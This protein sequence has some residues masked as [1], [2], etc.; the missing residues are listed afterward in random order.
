MLVVLRKRNVAVTK[1][2][3]ILCV[4][5]ALIGC[6]SPP[7]APV[8]A[9]KLLAPATPPGIVETSASGDHGAARV[10]VWAN[11]PRWGDWDAPVT[12][13]EFGDLEC[14]L[15]KSATTI[16]DALKLQ[17]GPRKLRVIWKH[18]P[19]PSHASA[20][21]SAD[22]AAIVMGL[23]GSEAFWKFQALAL[24]HQD[25]LHEETYADWAEASGVRREVYREAREAE[26]FSSKVEDDV[27][28]AKKLDAS[29]TPSFR[30]NGVTLTGAATVEQFKTLI[31][32]E[33]EKAS[34][35]V[36]AGTRPADVYVTL[37][38]QTTATTAVPV[39]TKAEG[40]PD[41]TVW[42][43]P[44]F[45]D[46]P[47]LGPADALVTV[48]EFSDF[49]CSFC[50]RVLPILEELRNNHPSEVRIVWKDHPLPFH[51]A[52][53]PSAIL[54]RVAYERLGNAGFWR[55]HAALFESQPNLEG[56]DLQGIAKT[57]GVP[58]GLVAAAIAK[59]E[60]KK[61]D[62]SVTLAEDLEATGTPYFFL[63]GVRL[64]G[65]VPL[66]EFEALFERRRAHALTL[67]DGGVPRE[68]IYEATIENGERAPGFPRVAVPEPDK[69][70]PARGPA[71]APV[72]I[73]VWSDFQ[74]PFCSRVLDT[75]RALEKEFAGR[76]K[77]AWRH[78]PLAFH[79]DAALASE[80]AQEVFVQRGAAAFWRYH[81]ALFAAQATPGGLERPQLETL[82]ARQGVNLTRFRQALDTH[83][84]QSKLDGDLAI[85]KSAG[86]SGTPTFVI[87]GYVVRGAQ[88]IAAFRKIVMLA[89]AEQRPDKAK[90]K[91]VP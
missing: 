24:K 80:A 16:L 53:R 74:C 36:A 49:Q 68:K 71:N 42:Q 88:P 25:E 21:S 91:M 56:Q 28:L 78:N 9:P 22:A 11:D 4:G 90:A 84:H 69:A 20:R 57:L 47:S 51:A 33:L 87:N 52:A 26:R 31:D 8:R 67:V 3:F 64:A 38:N 89:L 43:V 27:E 58:W 81:D 6:S 77:V 10:P 17:Y 72:T 59:S 75:L 14:P 61:I 15:T 18:L 19:Q 44:V 41:D 37:T 62:Q 55:A 46:D 45:A 70:T 7:S 35:L 5:V 40:A 12:I 1:R 73:Q 85:G 29:T 13:V 76:V 66:A 34:K 65:A 48:V 2:L 79:K 63:N 82:A 23:G 83:A 60:A 32:A 30:I 39:R 54:G 86:L 50:K